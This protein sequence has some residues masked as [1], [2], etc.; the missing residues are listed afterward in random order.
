LIRPVI[1]VVPKTPCRFRLYMV[2]SS[3]WR[4]TRPH[5]QGNGQPRSRAGAKGT[6]TTSKKL[7]KGKMTEPPMC[8]VTSAQPR[9]ITSAHKNSNNPPVKRGATL[10]RAALRSSTPPHS[11]TYRTTNH[12]NTARAPDVRFPIRQVER[13]TFPAEHGFGA[14]HYGS[15]PV[16]QTM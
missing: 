8:S 15:R 2:G 13:V 9:P 6:V 11:P 16:H 1:V 12:N 14:Q 4:I 5:G 3:R 10:Y 7:C